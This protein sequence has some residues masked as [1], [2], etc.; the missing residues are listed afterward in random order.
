MPTIRAQ[1]SDSP[2]QVLGGEVLRVTYYNP[3]NGYTI[4][5]IRA[6]AGAEIETLVGRLP[7]VQ[8][9]ELLQAEGRWIEHPVYGRQFAAER[10]SSSSPT[11]VEGLVRYLGSG[12]ISGLGPVLADRLVARFGER[13]LEVLD[14]EPWRIGEVPGIGAKRLDWLQNAWTRHRAMRDIMGFLCDNDISVAFVP[15]IYEQFGVDAPLVLAANPYRLCQEIPSVGFEAAER[16]ARAYGIPER[17]TVRLHAGIEAALR[18][19]T[20]EGHSYT[21]TEELLARAHQVLGPLDG[22]M[23]KD[24]LQQLILSGR[25]LAP[26][27]ESSSVQAEETLV[28]PTAPPSLTQRRQGGRAVRV[29]VAPS[30]LALE[31]HTPIY[32]PAYWRTEC[33][34][35]RRVAERSAR[36]VAVDDTRVRAWIE[37]WSAREGITL[38]PEQQQA[39]LDASSC[40]LFLLT[41]GPG[42]GKTTTLRAL[43]GLLRAMGKSVFLAAPTGKAAKRMREVT[44][45]EAKT[46]HRMLGAQPENRFAHDEEHPLAANVLIIDEVSMLDMFLADATLRAAGPQT[47]VILVGDSDQLPS[48]GPGQVLHDLLQSGTVRGVSRRAIVHSR[49]RQ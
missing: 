4:L 48:V 2:M 5:H 23:V 22:A 1:A 13:I 36:S 21:P 15:R 49:C 37:R 30:E 28:A 17:A 25:L 16:L 24:S 34:L 42:S 33:S 14:G 47:Q 32:L 45:I 46:L 31:P 41:G 29:F 9:G 19:A 10:Y 18:A 20:E 27:L 44:G 26:T 8:P 11:T 39:I 35:A 12:L 6:S 7:G 3:I 40:H 38:A 43:V